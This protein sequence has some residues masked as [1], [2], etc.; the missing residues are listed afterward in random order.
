MNPFLESMSEIPPRG[1]I[2]VSIFIIVGTRWFCVGG[3]GISL[4][5][6][7][8]KFFLKSLWLYLPI[9]VKKGISEGCKRFQRPLKAYKGVS[10]FRRRSN[11]WIAFPRC[12]KAYE[13]SKKLSKGSEGTST[14]I[15][16]R[17]SE[18]CK[19]FRR[20]PETSKDVQ[21]LVKLSHGVR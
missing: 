11:P 7:R 3:F 8:I 19:R 6:C 13:S 12:P 18:G 4:S 5:S 21:L 14:Q 17:V 20:L 2:L 16:I 10:S 1:N 15:N 9:F